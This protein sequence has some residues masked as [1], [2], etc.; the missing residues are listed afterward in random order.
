PSARAP[1]APRV[2]RPQQ[3]PERLGV[4]GEDDAEA[5]ADDA[6]AERGGALRLGLPGLADGAEE[7][8]ATGVGLAQ[9]GVA[10]VAVVAD[11]AGADEHRRS[12]RGARD[13]VDHGAGAVAAA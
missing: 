3:L 8:L 12:G 4:A 2:R 11:G 10:A 5:E 7:P 13:G 1:A 6:D 9:R